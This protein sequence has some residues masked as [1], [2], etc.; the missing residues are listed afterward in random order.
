[1]DKSQSGNAATMERASNRRR[2]LRMISPEFE[3]TRGHALPLGSTVRRGGVNFALFSA[4]A[5]RVTLVIFSRFSRVPIAEFPLDDRFNR[6]GNIWHA[7]VGGLNPGT[8][9]GYRIEGD[10]NSSSKIVGFDPAYVLIDP[11]C[12]AITRYTDEEG[13]QRRSVVIADHFEWENDAP[14]SI[15]L[16]DSIIYELHVRS[17]TQHESAGVSS[18]GTFAGLIEKIPYLKNLGVTAV[19]LM[20][21]FE[22][23]EHENTRLNPATGERLQNVWGYS[24]LSFFAP[25]LA[26]AG[27]TSGRVA[28]R[29]MKRM[30]KAFHSAGLE[31]IL[32]AVFNHTGEPER[33]GA[34]SSLRGIDNAVY[35]MLAPVTG[36]DRNYS[37][38]G[39]TLNC[40][41]PV[42]RNLIMD[43]LRYWVTEV[44][45]DGVRF[46]L[47]SIMGRGQDGSVLSNPPL[48]EDIAAD[49]VLANIKLIAEAWDAAGL[50]QVGEFSVGGRWAEWNGKFRDDIRR[51]LRGDAGM[52]PLLATRLAGSAD[53][54]QADGRSPCHSVNFVTCH[55]GFTLADLVSFDQKHNESNG[56]KSRDGTD[57]N[58]SWNCGA[59]GPTGDRSI[60]Q[61]RRRQQRNFATLLMVS[62]G[63]PMLLFGDESGRT[64][65]GNNNAY[66]Q[67][68]P[69]G[70]LI[71]DTPEADQSLLE[72]FRKLIAFRLEHRC[73]RRGSFEAVPHQSSVQLEWHGTRLNSPDWNPCSRSLALQIVDRD[74]HGEVVDRIFII[75]NAFWESLSFE[76]PQA[77]S[78]YWSRFVDTSIDAQSGD[79]SIAGGV[80]IC[81]QDRY[82]VGPRSAV[83]LVGKR[84]TT[85]PA[86]PSESVS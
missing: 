36:E 82:E 34:I 70:Q 59:E 77:K 32:D 66:C 56:E 30:V 52:V 1:L 11:Y 39:N 27:T 75:A 15:P 43:C 2:L 57:E 81:S 67:A 76:L 28:L 80:D 37:G 9:Y 79:G 6:T 41:H 23:D 64:Q 38:C 26:Y 48:I 55:D 44:H 65:K 45:I 33:G 16:A 50:Y 74:E 69:V 7:F 19:E 13:I 42:V 40:N 51:F 31:V 35:Y 47:A 46:D 10:A 60:L 62:H 72:F 21:V 14:P 84:S 86:R 73:L 58:F 17:F 24:P 18:P 4:H 5:T 12:R 8:A 68:G 78:W 53:L 20:P 3:I 85:G 54:F 61:L 83:V 22:F 63:V 49:P 71:W 25:H 29:E